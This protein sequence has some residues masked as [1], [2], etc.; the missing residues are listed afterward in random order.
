MDNI[1][2]G[3]NLGSISRA[4]ITCALKLGNVSSS[5]FTGQKQ[6]GIRWFLPA[7]KHRCAAN[8]SKEGNA[9]LSIDI[10]PSACKE[11]GKACGMNIEYQISK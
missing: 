5:H 3:L 4:E 9:N 1:T 10:I 7:E 6:F 2:G 11:S 8:P